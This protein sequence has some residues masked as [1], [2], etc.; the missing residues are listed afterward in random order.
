[1][2]ELDLTTQEQYEL[3]VRYEVQEGFGDQTL[4]IGSGG[5]ISFSE[6]LGHVVLDGIDTPIGVVDDGFGD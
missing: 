2:S 4:I 6:K 3:A 5:A 1:M